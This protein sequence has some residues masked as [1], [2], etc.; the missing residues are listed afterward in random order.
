MQWMPAPNTAERYRRKMVSLFPQ[1]ADARI[2]YVWGGFV[3]ISRV[4]TPHLGRLSP[5][6]YFAQGFSGHGVALTGIAGRVI[7]EA[8]GGQAG[9]FDLLPSCPVPPFPAAACC[10]RR[11]WF[12]R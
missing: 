4:R 11:C 9:R 10:A 8:I 7:A 12:W 3:G 5:T 6:T 2:D 1:L